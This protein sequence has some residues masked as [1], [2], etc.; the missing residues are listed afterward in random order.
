MGTSTSTTSTTDEVDNGPT[1][2]RNG[3]DKKRVGNSKPAKLFYQERIETED[4]L[5]DAEF[6][7]KSVNRVIYDNCIRSRHSSEV[8]RTDSGSEGNYVTRVIQ[9]NTE[10]IKRKRNDRY[11]YFHLHI[12]L[13]WF[14]FITISG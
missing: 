8:D 2:I 7:T 1:P 5:D 12:Y 9:L 13:K 14:K 10:K 11:S 6:R 3:V 4:E